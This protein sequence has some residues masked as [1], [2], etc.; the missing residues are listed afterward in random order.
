M[1]AA[2]PSSTLRV[3]TAAEPFK[4]L[5]PMCAAL[6]EAKARKG[7]TFE[8]IGKAIERDEVWIAA[9]FYGQAKLTP[10]DIASLSRVLELEQSLLEADLGANWWPRRG[11]GPMP[12]NDPV[13]YRLFEGVLVYG[14]A[15]KAIIHEKF[16]DG[17]QSMID[18]QVTVDKKEDPKGDRVVLTFD[19]KFLK[20]SQW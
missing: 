3:N 19:G 1:A 2:G 17:I 8:A 20:Y 16:G 14:H 15:I 5:P 10:K 7:L 18:C 6:F 4:D 9:A 13:L 12:P 11:L